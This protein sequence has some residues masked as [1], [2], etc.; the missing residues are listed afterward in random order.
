MILTIVRDHFIPSQAPDSDDSSI[1]NFETNMDEFEPTLEDDWVVFDNPDSNFSKSNLSQ[2]CLEE[3]PTLTEPLSASNSSSIPT[4][5]LH[6]EYGA[7]IEEEPVHNKAPKVTTVNDAVK[8][9]FKTPIDC[10]MKMCPLSLWEVVVSETNRYA[11]QKISKQVKRKRYFAG[12]KWVPV[13]L[14]DVMTYVGML[15]Y[16]MLYPQTGRRMRESWD[17]PYLS[18]WTKFMS[19]GRFQQISSVLHFNNNEDDIGC[20]MMGCI[21]FDQF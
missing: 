7:E 17:S 16:G 12:Y 15:I 10:F 20:K 8:S 5:G 6:W 9:D 13:T 3:E 11:E 2:Q 14:Q 18:P 19:R 21:K 4:T 1:E